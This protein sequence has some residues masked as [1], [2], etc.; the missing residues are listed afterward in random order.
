MALT[1]KDILELPSG[2]KMQL[3]AGKKG[4]HRSVVSAEIA[5]YEFAPDLGLASDNAFDI[6]DAMDSGSF[7]ITSLLFAKD[8]PTAILSA[9]KTMQEIGVAALAF[10]QILYDKLPDEVLAFA[11]ANDFPIFSFDKNVWFENIIFDIM[12]AV[13]FDDKVYLSEEK[14]D[15]M[16][17]G[18]MN[19]SELDIIL[20]GISLKLRQFVSVV[21]ISGDSLDAG[22]LL[23]S[24]YLFKGFQSKGLMVRYEDGVFLITTSSRMDHKSHDLI[25][26]EAFELL[27]ITEDTVWGMS[28]V[29][30][31]TAL[32]KAFRESRQC[33]IASAVERRS[34]PQ[35]SATGIY[36]VL[37]PS[38][39][40]EETAAFAG[41]VLHAI[42][43]KVD[44]QETAQEYVDAGGDIAKAAASLH[45]HQNTIRYRLG[46]I[47]TLTGMQDV[48]D[49]EL[50]LQ[51]K[52]ALVIVRARRKLAFQNP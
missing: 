10:K 13:Q 30:E 16:L 26:R 22:R 2:Q 11:D 52:T 44:L 41:D 23:R 51:L 21:Y 20:K 4:L 47:R 3:L 6:N 36:R 5:D 8:D 48:T 28:D 1:V 43:N 27:D 18:R 17:S 35:F 42:A 32:D 37:L 50:Y 33:C 25:R 34:F 24:F 39:D 49:S 29:H 15:A 31:R 45:C 19:R 14:I 7:V 12:Y 9:V 46:R 40:N 38:L